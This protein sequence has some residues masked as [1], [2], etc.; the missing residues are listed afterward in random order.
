MGMRLHKAIGYGMSH[1]DFL[2]HLKLPFIPKN[3]DLFSVI[4]EHLEQFTADKLVVPGIE[5]QDGLAG[6]YYAESN[7]FARYYL[8][9]GI[10]K[11]MNSNTPELKTA[12]DLYIGAN[13]SEKYITHIFFPDADAA[14]RW[15]R[16]DDDIDYFE[17]RWAGLKPKNDPRLFEP[18]IG[19]KVVY[20]SYGPYPYTNDIMAL[21]GTPRSWEMFTKLQ[22]DDNWAPRPPDHMRWWL[23]HTGVF[24]HEGVNVL[25]P[26]YAKWWG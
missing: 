13:D 15:Q 10:L 25:R 3:D 11:G 20:T 26:V 17:E 16:Y 21:D 2:K 18:K 1:A 7:S 22:T 8:H 14:F 5:K 6:P 4:E 12:F 23:T 24:D 9:K 19:N